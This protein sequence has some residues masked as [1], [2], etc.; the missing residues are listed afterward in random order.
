[1]NY[2]GEKTTPGPGPPSTVR[3]SV[4]QES[5][6][7]QARPCTAT[8][9][10]APLCGIVNADGLPCLGAEGRMATIWVGVDY[11]RQAGA[12]RRRYG[13]NLEGARI[14]V[15]RYE[16]AG[17]IN[18]SFVKPEA[19]SLEQATLALPPDAAKRLA[20]LLLAAVDAGVGELEVAT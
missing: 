20:Y 17:A 3:G 11:L 2:L 13:G 4:A 1:M 10:C 9:T 12:T 14:R 15:R 7:P 19:G 5:A 16:L 8:G 18:I 6:G